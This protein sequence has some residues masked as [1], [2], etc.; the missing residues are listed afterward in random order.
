[1]ENIIYKPIGIIHSSSKTPKGT[2]I[3]PLTDKKNPGCVE[4][5]SEFADG[6]QD[7]SGFSHLYLIYHFHLSKKHKLK[8]IPFLDDCERGVFSTR[9]PSRPNSIGLSLVKLDKI[10]DNKLFIRS[11]DIV[12]GTPLIDIKPYVNEFEKIE[13]CK[14]GWLQ[15]KAKRFKSIKGDDRF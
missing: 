6:L 8:V 14:I 2:P 5:F 15:Y 11:L 13:D 3:Q 7:L 10:E 4:V 1:M 9:A 12:D